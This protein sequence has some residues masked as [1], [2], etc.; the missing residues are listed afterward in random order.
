VRPWAKD[1]T[2]LAVLAD[3]HEWN[4]EQL[5][6]LRRKRQEYH[7]IQKAQRYIEVRIGQLLEEEEED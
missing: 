7:E 1:Q 3:M 6:Y 4:E 2:D 5:K